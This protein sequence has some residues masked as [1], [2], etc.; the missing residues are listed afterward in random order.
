[1]NRYNRKFNAW[2]KRFERWYVIKSRLSEFEG[3]V[4]DYNGA[5]PEDVKV[6]REIHRKLYECQQM[7]NE[8][9]KDGFRQDRRGAL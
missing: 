2:R 4:N 1:M 3:I 9:L 5:T 8:R 6:L 7:A